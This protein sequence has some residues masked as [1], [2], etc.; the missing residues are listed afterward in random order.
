MGKWYTLQTAR[1]KIRKELGIRDLATI[2]KFINKK[3][4]PSLKAVVIGDDK[5]KRYRIKEEWIDSFVSD[6]ENLE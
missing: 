4:K 6:F 1:E 3:E 5:G 2:K